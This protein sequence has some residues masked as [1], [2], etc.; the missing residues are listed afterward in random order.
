MLW[1]CLRVVVLDKLKTREARYFY[2]WWW[3]WWWLCQDILLNQ[4]YPIPRVNMEWNSIKFTYFHSVKS[5]YNYYE[6]I[7]KKRIRICIHYITI[8]NTHSPLHFKYVHVLIRSWI[9]TKQIWKALFQL[10]SV[11]EFGVMYNGN[12]SFHILILL[13]YQAHFISQWLCVY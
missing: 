3:W 7:F 5:S 13:N 2:W 9:I 6:L 10:I 4:C 1:S 11:I 12:E 8:E